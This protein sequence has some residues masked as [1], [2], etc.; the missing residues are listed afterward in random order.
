LELFPESGHFKYT[1]LIEAGRETAT[2]ESRKSCRIVLSGR[3]AGAFC[4]SANVNSEAIYKGNPSLVMKLKMHIM[5]IQA[6]T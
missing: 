3:T 4:F 5:H 6:I 1:D 2:L